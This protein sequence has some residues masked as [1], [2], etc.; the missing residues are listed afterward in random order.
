VSELRL[1]AALDALVPVTA[2]G[3]GAEWGEIRH[4]AVRL[5]RRRRRATVLLAASLSAAAFGVLAAS[6]Q[7]AA[8]VPHS[9]AP[10]LVV[11]TALMTPSGKR[12]GTFQVEIDRAVVAFRHGV[13]VVG[14]RTPAGD[15]YHARW[16][17]DVRG[18]DRVTASLRPGQTLC[19][20][21]APHSSEKLELTRAQVAALVRSSAK[22]TVTRSSGRQL[23]GT[24]VLQRS[25]MRPGVMC[26]RPGVTC[27]RIYTGRR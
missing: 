2:A 6:G 19:T 11:R 10:H 21:C 8:L 22:V 1:R 18:T 23:K 26:L 25:S 20:G 13:R 9:K 5:R 14:F 7:I 24:P 16:F 4:R 15:R 3:A 17:L 27:T 12:A